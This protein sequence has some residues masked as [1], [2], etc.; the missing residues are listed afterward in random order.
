[1]NKYLF[2]IGSTDNFESAEDLESSYFADPL[3]F[4]GS[5]YTF[6]LP[7][8][9]DEDVPVLVGRGFAFSNDWCMDDTVS[10]LLVTG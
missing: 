8:G 9:L 5:A 1:M 2:L 3:A 7:E 4:R 6:D 10:L